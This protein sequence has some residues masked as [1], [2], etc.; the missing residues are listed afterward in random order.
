[1]V[2]LE[3]HVG[4]QVSIRMYIYIYLSI[5]IYQLFRKVIESIHQKSTLSLTKT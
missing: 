4:M 3:P 2:E 1:M 5:H